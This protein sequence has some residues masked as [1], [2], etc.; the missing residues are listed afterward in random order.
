MLSP[1]VRLYEVGVF[2][3]AEWTAGYC[4]KSSR[5]K[6]RVIDLGDTYYLHWLN[7]LEGSR[8]RRTSGGQVDVR[9]RQEDAYLAAA[10]S[11]D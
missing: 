7:V 1:A 9:K 2:E 11:A 3:W 4:R 8:R 6:P 10:R 5:P